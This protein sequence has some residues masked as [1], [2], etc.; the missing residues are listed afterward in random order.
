MLVA[1]MCPITS[2]MLPIKSGGIVYHKGRYLLLK[3]HVRVGTP[4]DILTE[5]IVDV[6][7]VTINNDVGFSNA[8]RALSNE[9]A[10]AFVIVTVS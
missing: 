3:S 6:L 1:A 7:Y 9:S 2:F 4:G 10:L 5:E 8:A